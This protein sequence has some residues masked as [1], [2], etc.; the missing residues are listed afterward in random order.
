MSELSNLKHVHKITE[1]NAHV[2]ILDNGAVIDSEAEAML[3]A[4]HSR[5]IG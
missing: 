3:Q 2:Y 1:G 5:S 4:L